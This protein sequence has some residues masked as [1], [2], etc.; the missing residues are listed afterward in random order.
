[1]LYKWFIVA[2]YLCVGAGWGIGIAQASNAPEPAIP[3]AR[4]HQ[5]KAP[6]IDFEHLRDPFTSYL[7]T[8]ALRG[9]R[10]L[11]AQHSKLF[12]RKREPLE[13]FDLSTL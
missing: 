2:S 9:Q 10:L 3:D 4:Q 13:V 12:N 8:I 7:D 5:M 11:K 1:M 6:S